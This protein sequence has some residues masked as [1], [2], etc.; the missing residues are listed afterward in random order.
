[1][2]YPKLER[3]RKKNLVYNVAFQKKEEEG[4]IRSEKEKPLKKRFLLKLSWAR[5][6]RGGDGR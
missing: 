6:W 1:L 5:V 4:H 2:L 3:G